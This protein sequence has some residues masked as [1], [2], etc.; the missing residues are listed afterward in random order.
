MLNKW[1]VVSAICAFLFSHCN[2]SLDFFSWAQSH[3]KQTKH[4]HFPT[5]FA[6]RY[7][8][9]LDNFWPMKCRLNVTPLQSILYTI[10]TY[11]TIIKVIRLC[12]LLTL[13]CIANSE[14]WPWM[15]V[16]MHS[17]LYSFSLFL[18]SDTWDKNMMVGALAVILDLEEQDCMYFSAGRSWVPEYF[19]E[20][21][22]Y[23]S[24]TLLDLLICLTIVIFMLC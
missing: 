21:N 1:L 2:R 6:V 20:Y 7:D 23:T 4:L 22:Y 3:K 12:H 10:Q 5:S 8:Q 15:T 9:V 17:L 13:C 11:K 18:Y 16:G 24:S 14:I 19:R